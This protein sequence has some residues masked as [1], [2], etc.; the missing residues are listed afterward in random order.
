MQNIPI[1]TSNNDQSTS[2]F[3][4]PPCDY[5]TESPESKRFESYSKKVRVSNMNANI[6][7]ID[8]NEN[9]S[10]S[11]NDNS[12]GSDIV[13]VTKISKVHDADEYN[14]STG[15]TYSATAIGT[16]IHNII[17]NCCITKPL[18]KST[19]I[20][21][22]SDASAG[23]GAVMMNAIGQDSNKQWDAI[24]SI[25]YYDIV[26][27]HV[28]PA[29]HVLQSDDS[30][31]MQTVEINTTI[32]TVADL[33]IQISPTS[34]PF[35]NNN[36]NYNH[37]HNHTQGQDCHSKYNYSI[38]LFAKSFTNEYSYPYNDTHTSSSSAFK[39]IQETQS[40]IENP[41]YT[42]S[43]V[44]PQI[45]FSS[46]DNKFISCIIP[47]PI[48]VYCDNMSSSSRSMQSRKPC[49]LS[50]VVIFSL[51]WKKKSRIMNR[52]S[53][54]NINNVNSNGITPS[55]LS[56]SSTTSKKN[57]NKMTKAKNTKIPIPFYIQA[58]LDDD[59]NS[60]HH[61]HHQSNNTSVSISNTI[62]SPNTSSIHLN[63]DYNNNHNQNNHYTPKVIPSHAP[64]IYNPRT[65][66]IDDTLYEHTS[67][68]NESH[69][70]S[71]DYHNGTSNHQHHHNSNYDEML[72][73]KASIL[74]SQITSIC[75]IHN[76]NEYD[77]YNNSW[78]T[79]NSN[80]S[81]K[82][83]GKD[84]IQAHPL[85]LAG[86]NDGSILLIGYKR[87]K[88]MALLYYH[89]TTDDNDHPSN[90]ILNKC[91]IVH[92]MY[93][94]S[95]INYYDHQSEVKTR[96][97]NDNIILNGKDSNDHTD[98]GCRY[99][100]LIIIQRNRETVFYKTHFYSSSTYHHYQQQK[101]KQYNNSKNSRRQKNPIY[102]KREVDC[103]LLIKDPKLNDNQQHLF[104]FGHGIFLE[105]DIVAF[106]IHPFYQNEEESEI[107][108]VWY[109]GDIEKGNGGLLMNEL[110]LNDERLMALN[111]GSLSM[112]KKSLRIKSIYSNNVSGPGPSSLR[113]ICLRHFIA[114]LKLHHEKRTNSLVI[115]S[116]VST[117]ASGSTTIFLRPFVTIW[118]WKT[119]RIG[120]T[121]LGESLMKHDV[122][123]S[124]YLP[125]LM[126]DWSMVGNEK[127]SYSLQNVCLCY[128]KNRGYKLS[129]IS[130]YDDEIFQK[131]LLCVGLLSPSSARNNDWLLNDINEPSTLFLNHDSLLYLHC[132]PVSVIDHHLLTI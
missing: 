69:H 16:C 94:C 57:Q 12:N 76:S 8:D 26:K 117:S 103:K 129:Y 52:S 104:K 49:S 25:R 96:H 54:G 114:N 47:H 37:N 44:V 53:S 127:Q 111:H 50:S 79:Y 22:N 27:R 75:D 122:L 120:F 15:T 99:G 19:T 1:V 102:I 98:I 30:M 36:F 116:A 9:E 123:K 128:D 55:S 70:H 105:Y 108:Q 61:F 43:D 38:T 60:H 31:H 18:T 106:L 74:L 17:P 101:E 67:Y 21:S 2:I 3:R 56:S 72:D 68:Y 6:S 73:Q 64:T 11:G 84:I 40:H 28:Q 121:L 82:G 119:S 112:K 41:K 45:I 20:G 97:G 13:K 77:D 85:L 83:N 71:Q 92:M 86:C 131:Q 126:N 62:S 58:S 39:T 14:D 93:M 5:S 24:L 42:W 125:P 130:E 78:M 115:S 88:L 107:A 109:I 87:A 66:T 34:K 59:E 100:R 7:N 81:G 89:A 110:I 10:G 132:T 51:D 124:H 95:P 32:T 33:H 65:V 63:K 4:I 46:N 23:T 80:H 48:P 118:N 113:T 91:G 90:I 35:T 29:I